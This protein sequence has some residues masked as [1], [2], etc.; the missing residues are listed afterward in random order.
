MTWTIDIVEVGI[1]PDLPMSIYLPDAGSAERLDVP[2]YCYLLTTAGRRPIL[3]DTGPDRD[4]SARSGFTIRGDARPAIVAALARRDLLLV[5]VHTVAQS[6]L[7]YDHMQNGHLFPR[8][9]VLVQRSE[10]EWACSES[11]G[12]FYVGIAGMLESI[13]DRLQVLDGKYEVAPGVTL[14]PNGGHSP[15]HQS[16]LVETAEGPVCLC[17]DIIPMAANVAIVPPSIDEAATCA[18]MQRVK[19]EGWEILPGH[20]PILRGDKR[21]V[22]PPPYTR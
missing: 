5:D 14:L 22:P 15:G 16:A 4:A 6:H 9:S 10:L 13:G 8:A 17:I 12:P 3:V 21:Y 20:D 1:I 19:Q 11:P 7:H 18:F 2:C